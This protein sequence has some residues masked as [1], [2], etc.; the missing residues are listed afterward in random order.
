MKKKNK[1]KTK[2]GLH[3]SPWKYH[4][5]AKSGIDVSVRGLIFDP[6]KFHS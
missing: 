1:D 3:R 4:T 6:D 2:I 5:E